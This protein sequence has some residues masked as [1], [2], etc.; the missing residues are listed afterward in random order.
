MRKKVF[1]PAICLFLFTLSAC[2]TTEAVSSG[3]YPK[4]G[5]VT[6]EKGGWLWVFRDGSKELAEYQ[7]GEA[8]E[9]HVTVIGRGPGGRTVKGPDTETVLDY[10]VSKPGF[11]TDVKDGRIWVFREGSKELAEY[12]KGKELDK[13][14]IM[15]GK[16]P[17]GMTMKAVD[18]DTLYA[19]LRTM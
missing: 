9:K 15:I 3:P 17:G 7:K 19:Y 5:F 6:A 12:Q 1:L 14:V 18:T 4:K 13:H 8:L 2:A 11:V 10:M 16:G